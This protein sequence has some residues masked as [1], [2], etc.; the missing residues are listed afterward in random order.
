MNV[1]SLG[2]IYAAGN[3]NQ[4][5]VKLVRASD[6]TDVP[7]GSVTVASP[8]GTAGQFT[9]V[10]LPTPITLAANTSYNLVSSETLGGDFWYDIGTVAVP[11]LVSVNG[12]VYWNGSSTYGG[13]SE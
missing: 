12:P 11:S 2:R 7:G 13:Q 3:T 10:Q 9:Y 4:H 8:A 5:V 1:T 6:G